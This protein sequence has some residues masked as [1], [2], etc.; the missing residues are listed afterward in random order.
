M[1]DPFGSLT[2]VSRL[3]ESLERECVNYCHWK[4]NAAID[5]SA[6]GDNDL[7]LLIDGRDLGAFEDI[8]HELDFV[9]AELPAER[10]SVGMSDFYGL[11][12]T[13][14]LVHVHAHSRLVLGDDATKNYR[15]PLERAYLDSATQHGLF[16]T[17]SPEFEYFVFVIRMVLKHA[18]AD[19]IASTKGRLSDSEL[20]ELDFLVDRV[21][22]DQV[23]EILRVHASFI[24]AALFQRCEQLLKTKSGLRFRTR[25]AGELQRRLAPWAGRSP[26]A[27]SWLRMWR[28]V[29]W[30][31]HKYVLKRPP[32]RRLTDGGALIAIV[33]GDGA[34][35]S[36]A[37][38]GVAS[39]LSKVFVVDR[40]HLGKPP[41]S[42]ATSS[43][44]AARVL[45]RGLRG[46]LPS[47]AAM[48]ST[49]FRSR[50]KVLDL[51]WNAQLARDRHREYQRVQRLVSRGGIAVCDRFPL[52]ESGTV[53]GP[54]SSSL[55]LDK[56]PTPLARR[57]IEW[58]RSYYDRIRD[59][60]ILVVLRVDPEV[61]VRRRGDE[62][63]DFVRARCAEIWTKDWKGTGALIVDANRPHSEVLLSV[64][65]AIWREL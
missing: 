55:L 24:S 17:P 19:A 51:L 5:R 31:F 14:V 45:R 48:T 36:S 11:D 26:R 28:R 2:L 21:R 39:W 13:G 61:A 57:L 32:R 1:E 60:D 59:P 27:D 46:S 8:L 34:G 6:R 22:R 63:A 52:R 53:D 44:R 50:P 43:L 20:R 9:G 47:G 30:R 25:T 62:D 4:S 37:V 33:G 58:E 3:C 12:E 64:K 15:M 65:S 42:L 18:T 54:R 10:R 38:E 29:Y 49:A 23:D 35:K 16:R 41:R 56:E 7:D 40:A